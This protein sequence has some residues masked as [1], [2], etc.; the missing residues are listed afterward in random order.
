[1]WTWMRT[2]TEAA[3]SRRLIQWLSSAWASWPCSLPANLGRSEL[4]C[5][6]QSCQRIE[7]FDL[8]LTKICF[9]FFIH[10][11]AMLVQ[12]CDGVQISVRAT[13]LLIHDVLGRHTDQAIWRRLTIGLGSS[14]SVAVTGFLGRFAFVDQDCLTEG[15]HTGGRMEAQRLQD[16]TTSQD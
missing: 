8:T 9:V 16:A 12:D 3:W 11:F 13:L 2:W 15:L 4:R 1:M 10:L 5:T 6:S 7:T 14:D